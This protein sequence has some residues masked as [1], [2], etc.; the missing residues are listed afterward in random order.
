M[1]QL[2]ALDVFPSLQAKSDAEK[3][4][5]GELPRREVGAM[6]LQTHASP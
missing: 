2:D 1:N 4:G 3:L 6:G 5:W